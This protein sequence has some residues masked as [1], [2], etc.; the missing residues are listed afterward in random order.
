MASQ[1]ALVPHPELHFSSSSGARGQPVTEPFTIEGGG[2][3]PI[4]RLVR[5]GRTIIALSA[6]ATGSAFLDAS[7][8]VLVCGANDEGQLNPD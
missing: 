7:G 2:P 1:Q 6:T 4:A 5:P 8:E 3:R